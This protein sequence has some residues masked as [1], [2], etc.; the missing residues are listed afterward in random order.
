MGSMDHS[1]KPKNLSQLPLGI[2]PQ[3]EPDR[4]FHKGG[5]SFYFFDL[6]DNILHL[7]TPIYIFNKTTKKEKPVSTAEFAQINSLLG[8]S[9]PYLDYEVNF[10]HQVGSF[11]RFRDPLSQPPYFFED[12]KKL[13]HRPDYEWKGPSWHFFYYAVLNKRPIAIITARGHH[14]D[15]INQ[16][17]ELLASYGHLPHAPEIFSTYP[18]SHPETRISLG[19]SEQKQSTAEL[20]EKAIVQCVHDAMKHFGESQYHRFGMSDDDPSN[21]ET[22]I[23]AMKYLKKNHYPDNSFYVFSADS[24]PVIKKKILTESVET[25]SFIPQNHQQSL[26]DQIDHPSQNDSPNP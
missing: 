14:P 9:D 11:R 26:F 20:K 13:V 21:L 12:L 8:K 23:R 22:A 1:S 15:T 24:D 17:L 6:D 5:R 7:D 19:D 25:Q 16:G 10:D 2:Q 3:V 4:N 18:V